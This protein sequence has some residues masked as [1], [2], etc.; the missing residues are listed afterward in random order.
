MINEDL[1]KAHKFTDAHSC[2]FINKQGKLIRVKC[3]FEVTDVSPY[4]NTI[5][6][7][8]VVNHV[9]SISNKIHFEINNVI[10]PHSNYYL[11]EDD[12]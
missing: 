5:L 2:L 7:S 1:F 4:A 10:C 8:S 6:G 11:V 3:P 12:T 9:L